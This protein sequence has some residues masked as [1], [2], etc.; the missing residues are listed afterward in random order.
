MTAEDTRGAAAPALSEPDAQEVA[1]RSGE[2]MYADDLAAQALGITLEEIRPGYAR[3]RMAVRDSMLNGHGTC[4]GGYIFL[5]ADTAFA[6]ACNS[7]N[8]VTF[9]ASAAIDFLAPAHA[10]DVLFAV[11]EEQVRGARLGVYDVVVTNQR[12]Q[13][14]AL[15]RGRSYQVR[16]TLYGEAGAGGEGTKGSE[17]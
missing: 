14:L 3:M 4:H 5:F 13:R 15:F 6:F 10:E 8:R 1:R 17:S 11:A 2:A 12:G 7:Y 9:A 16:G